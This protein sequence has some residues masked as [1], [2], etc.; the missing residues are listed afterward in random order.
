MQYSGSVFKRILA[1]F[2]SFLMIV[3]IL[4]DIRTE[5]KGEVYYVSAT[6]GNDTYNGLSADKPFRTLAHA[7]EK[8][9]EG[10]ICYVMGGV[11]YESLI[12]SGKKNLTF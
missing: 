2:I 12:V 3:A 10:S 4:P 7:V 5:A 9:S 6:L 8:M 1:M 11:Y